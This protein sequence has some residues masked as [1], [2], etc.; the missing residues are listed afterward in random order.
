MN[1]SSRLP[2]LLGGAGLLAA[3]L[4]WWIDPLR[5]RVAWTAGIGAWLEWPLGSLAL[6]M[7]H[8][9]T[10]GRWGVAIGPALLAGVFTLP[11]LIPALLPLLLHMQ[12]LYPWVHP[13]HRLPNGFYLNR[14]FFLI[15]GGIY[16]IVWFGLAALM[17]LRR[18]RGRDP[19]AGFAGPGLLLLAITTTFAAIDLTLSLKPDFNSSIWGMVSATGSGLMALAIATLLS[20]ATAQR[21]TLADLGKLLLGLV[22]LWAYLDFMQFLIVWESDLPSES[23]WYLPRASGVWLG[24]VVLIAAG[25]FLLPFAVLIF[26]RLQ[27]S[28]MAIAL[29]AGWLVL[30]EVLRVWWLVLPAVPHGLS[31]IA[32]AVALAF[33]GLAAGL[34]RL[35]PRMEAAHA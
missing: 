34:A 11:L 16:L 22:V 19:A 10:G 30:M 21:E 29:V 28:R 31:W 4:G 7:V 20:A 26:P 5:F 9:L 14:P 27:R 6:L 32:F 3:L 1:R 17:L 35:A 23:G 2:W 8:S 33:A 15:R 24:A 18:R 13:A 25:H 12:A